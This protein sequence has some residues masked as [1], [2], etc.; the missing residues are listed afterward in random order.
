MVIRMNDNIVG[1]KK[2][3]V[4][5]D[6]VSRLEDSKKARVS[7][8]VVTGMRNYYSTKSEYRSRVNALYEK[9]KGIKP[10][11]SEIN[12]VIY[13]SDFMERGIAIKSSLNAFRQIW[14]EYRLI[15]NENTYKKE[16]N[17][18]VVKVEEKKEADNLDDN[19]KRLYTKVVNLSKYIEDFNRKKIDINRQIAN[20]EDKRRKLSI[21]VDR[22][23]NAK[24]EFE[25]YKI[26]EQQKIDKMKNEVNTKVLSLQNLIDNLDNI[27]DKVS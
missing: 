15:Y 6:I 5:N 1:I 10:I 25:R 26:E 22:L 23:E 17:E 12:N 9:L 8:D 20:L 27:L 19:Y 4:F 11:D 7:D 2:V 18:S 21:E 13:L 14:V 24:R 16:N 3:D